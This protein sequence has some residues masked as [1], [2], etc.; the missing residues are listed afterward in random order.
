MIGFNVAEAGHPVT[1]FASEDITSGAT[2]P[3][4]SM[5]RYDHASILVCIGA[6]AGAFTKMFVK[7]C[8]AESGGTATA[9]AFN[10]YKQE[11]LGSPTSVSD[12][13]GVRTNVLAAGLTPV[14]LAGAMYVIEIDSAEL[15]DGYPWVEV[16]FTNT[17]QSILVTVV[18]ILSAGRYQYA[19]SPTVL[20]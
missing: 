4:F 14:G 9:I 10:V 16:S 5:K 19:S 11:A 3:R 6:A 17:A 1:L 20:S 2:C 15:S 7:N 18:A 8:T 12:V 13:L